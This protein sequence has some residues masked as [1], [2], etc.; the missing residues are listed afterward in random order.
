MRKGFLIKGSIKPLYE[1][2]RHSIVCFLTQSFKSSNFITL[3]CFIE[4]R[5]VMVLSF[6]MGFTAS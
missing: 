6:T 2:L 5:I 3:I 1:T 4:R